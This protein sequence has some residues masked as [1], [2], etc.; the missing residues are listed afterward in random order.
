MWHVSSS[1]AR[2]ALDIVDGTGP[3]DGAGPHYSRRSPGS[4]TFTGCG[5][6]VVLV[7]DD[8][9]AVWAVILQRTPSKRG[10][11]DSRG[12]EGT[13]HLGRL[14]WRNNVFRNL[15]Q[16]L[17]SELIEAATQRTYEE[18]LKKYGTLPD[19]PLRTEVDVRKVR[20]RNPGYCYQCAGWTKGP[21]VRGKLHLF[22]PSSEVIDE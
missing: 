22:A 10:T 8:G 3:F 21:V 15:G 16:T 19:V 20:S 1:G 14:V 18:W 11:G 12:R 4:R 5:S 17:S 9:T 6:E 13:K 2:E 7:S